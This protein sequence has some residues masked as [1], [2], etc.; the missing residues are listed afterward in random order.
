MSETFKLSISVS[1][2]RQNPRKP[3]MYSTDIQATDAGLPTFTNN[4]H[5]L[6]FRKKNNINLALKHHNS[7]IAYIWN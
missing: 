1:I 4:D 2:L 6:I 5:F 7:K 3:E